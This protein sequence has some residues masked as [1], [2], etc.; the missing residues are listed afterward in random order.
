M[1]CRFNIAPLLLAVVAAAA[2]MGPRIGR[3]STW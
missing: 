1:T 3:F 2:A